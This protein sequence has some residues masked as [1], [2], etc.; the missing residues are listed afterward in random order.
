MSR[1]TPLPQHRDEE[2][3][4]K[5]A[6]PTADPLSLAKRLEGIPVLAR[7][8][9]THLH[10][11]NVYYDTPEQV[12][13]H[14]RVAL[15]LRRVAGDQKPQWLQ[16]LKT[17]GGFDSAL[18]QRG[19]WE[20]TIRHATLSWQA[21]QNTPWP[22]IDPAGTVF[23]ALAPLFV[24]T[25]ER[26][27]WLLHRRDGSV[28]EV[29][30][31]IGE[32]VV[33]GKSEPICELELEIKMGQPSALFD[34][35]LEIARTITVLP[36][37]VSKA[38]RGYTL[39]QDGVVIALHAKPQVL[40]SDL[41]L[42][43]TAQRV[44]FE[45]FCQFTTNLNALQSSDD[46]EVVH[47]AR[48][49]WRRFRSAWRFFRP[50]LKN[51]MVPYGQAVQVLL[52]A[53]G[54]LRDLDVARTET[55]PPLAS[56]FTAGDPQRAALWQAMALALTPATERQRQTVREA[57]QEPGVGGGLL[58]IA[59]WLHGLAD[60]SATDDAKFASSASR[61]NWLKHRI[62]HLHRRL[63]RACQEDRKPERQHRVR[64]LAKRI[65]YAIEALHTLLPR[66]RRQRWYQQAITL[67]TS[68][69]ARRDVMQAAA[70]ITELGVDR[71]L[72]EFLMDNLD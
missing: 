28:V 24:T 33:G 25:F 60:S 15:R 40:T 2:I 56:A 35:G 67:Q 6:L 66:K 4:L 62:R 55:L 38:E 29:A 68:I 13:R 51:E 14:Q 49:G 54:K 21:L 12:L 47:Q 16:T 52:T 9:P 5:L 27:L 71:S 59:Q 17:G 1:M 31:D 70:L 65:R 8:Q 44:L 57:L 20:S 45:M 37:N 30:L 72:A 10:L 3:E 11:Y 43:E 36:L 41:P 64:I 58:A 46:S 63:K 61:R 23:R 7:H 48:I 26:T 69:G 42:P 19:E 34:I 18:S 39:A 50:V 22:S 32:I 53:L